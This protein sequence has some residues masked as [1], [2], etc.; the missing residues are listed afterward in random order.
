M[1]RPVN[2]FTPESA[3]YTIDKF[4]EITNWAI[5]KNKQ[6]RSKV[7]VY[8]FLMNGH[9]VEILSIESNVRKLCITQCFRL[10]VKRLR[11]IE[12][13]FWRSECPDVEKHH[14]LG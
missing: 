5:L 6:Y 9:T 10:G 13:L 2:S 8:S 11:N 7:L 1:Q 12:S 14:A 4:P 3:K